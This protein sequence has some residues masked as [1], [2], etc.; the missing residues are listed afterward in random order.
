ML[1][2]SWSLF[3][4]LGRKFK[5][6]RKPWDSHERCG[7]FVEENSKL[8]RWNLSL[9]V[10]VVKLLKAWMLPDVCA[11]FWPKL[12]C[13]WRLNLHHRINECSNGEYVQHH[14]EFS[15]RIPAAFGGTYTTTVLQIEHRAFMSEQSQYN[16]DEMNSFYSSSK[17]S[18]LHKKEALSRCVWTEGLRWS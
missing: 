16:Q 10:P 4:P 7:V 6:Q 9:L 3:Q 1:L 14:K 15:L 12:C 17:K 8:H 13:D 5:N 18:N 2:E 11:S